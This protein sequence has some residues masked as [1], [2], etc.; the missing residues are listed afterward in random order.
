MISIN[1]LRFSLGI[2]FL[3]NVGIQRVSLAEVPSQSMGSSNICGSQVI[4]NNNSVICN[5]SNWPLNSK[6]QEK[7]SFLC[8]DENFYP[9]PPVLVNTKKTYGVGEIISIGYSGACPNKT[10]FLIVPANQ[11]PIAGRN[12]GERRRSVLVSDY[13]GEIRF[14]KYKPS[15]PGTYVVNSYFTDEQ[16][17]VFLAG[18]S[19][20]FEVISKF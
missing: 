18:R 9:I 7:L 2:L 15:N 17:T 8:Q 13:K 12:T 11:K 16:G 5:V 4:G 10:E 3:T 6:Q 19:F 14:K 1:I 20:P